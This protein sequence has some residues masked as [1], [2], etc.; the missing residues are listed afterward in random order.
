MPDSSTPYNSWGVPPRD[1]R[2]VDARP[3]DRRVLDRLLDAGLSFQRAEQHVETG[4]V[5]LDGEVVTDLY[6]LAPPGTRLALL[7]R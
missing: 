4:H 1:G 5:E 2:F 7:V 6:H 3:T